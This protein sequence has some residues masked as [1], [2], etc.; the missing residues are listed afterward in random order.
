MSPR[1]PSFRWITMVLAC[2]ALAMATPASADPPHA[3]TRGAEARRGPDPARLRARLRRIE[4]R[5]VHELSLDEH[6]AREVRRI[7]DR[8]AERIL[9]VRR[10]TARGPERRLAAMR[11]RHDAFDA[12][13]GLLSCE[14]K[15]RFRTLERRWREEHARRRMARRGCG[16][17]EGRGRGHG[18]RRHS[19]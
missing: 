15:D 13:Y 18:R 7:L 19:R 11:A 8:A 14:E 10:E 12:I 6:R 2:G 4:E 5:V 16:R 3:S 9:R 1:S 17:H